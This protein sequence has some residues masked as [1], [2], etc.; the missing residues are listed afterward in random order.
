MIKKLSVLLLFFPLLLSSAASETLTLQEMRQAEEITSPEDESI[1][2]ENARTALI[3]DIINLAKRLFEETHNTAKRAQNSGDIY[4]CK[5][6]TVHCFCE[7][8]GHFRLAAYPDTLLVIPNNKKAKEC[9]PYAYGIA[10]QDIPAESGNPFFEAASFR[11]DSSVSKEEN[12]ERARAFLQQVRRGDFFQ[13]SANYYYGVGAHSLIFIADYDP[14]TD[15]VRW[16]DSNMKGFSKNGVRYGYVQYDAVREIDWF[17]DAF[18]Q[19][20]RGATLYRLRD[21]IV[22]VP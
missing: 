11:Y 13:M 1:P 16:T 20:K 6:F 5:N 14:V 15:T 4:V 8:A 10:W 18:C 7:C 19:R 21:D 17:V 22:A 12:R 9:E 2:T 3:D